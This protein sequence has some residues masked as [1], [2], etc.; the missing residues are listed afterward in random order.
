MLKDEALHGNV[1]KKIDK[2]IDKHYHFDVDTEN[3]NHYQ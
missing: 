2:Y 1:K 3:E